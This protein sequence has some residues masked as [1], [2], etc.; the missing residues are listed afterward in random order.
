MDHRGDRLLDYT[1]AGYKLGAALPNA[2]ELVDPSR[3]VNLSP[4]AGDNRS[5]IQAAI[6][7]VATMPLNSNGYRGVVQLAAGQYDISDTLEIGASGVILRGVGDGA[8]AARTRSSA[9]PLLSRS[10]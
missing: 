10:T 1:A 3:F 8:S 2:T 9:P 6:D 5:Q 4:V 7:Q